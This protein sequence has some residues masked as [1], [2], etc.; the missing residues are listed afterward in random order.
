M[1]EKYIPTEI[2]DI[3]SVDKLYSLHYFAYSKN[4]RFEG[5]Q[6]NFWEIVYCDSG[7]A[8]ITDIDQSF[9][10]S[11]GQAFIHAPNHFHNVRPNRS[12]TNVIVTGF[13]G[14]LEPIHKIAGTVLEISNNERVFIKNML[15]QSRKVFSAPLNLVYQYSLD[16]K[17]KAELGALQNIK[18]CLEC[19]LLFLLEEKSQSSKPADETQNYIVKQMINIM[20]KSIGSKLTIQSLS[21]KLGYSPTYLKKLFKETMGESIIQYFIRLK[22]EKAKSYISEGIYS[23]SDISEML[24]YDTLQYFSKQFKD[25]T[26][27][28]PS[29]YIQS[30]KETG[31]LK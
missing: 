24:G 9:I 1:E 12:N 3:I 18:N 4:F 11:Q 16:L 7:E 19:L 26:N 5:E 20:Q 2:K 8:D 13:D 29:D 21:Y 22:I 31:I 30:I 27:M 28:S 14:N 23:I 15:S 10:L 6:H 25:I 17:E